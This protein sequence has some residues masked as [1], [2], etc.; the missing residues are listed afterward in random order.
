MN[1]LDEFYS[2]NSN[3]YRMIH[4]FKSVFLVSSSQCNL[5]FQNGFLARSTGNYGNLWLNV[6]FWQN[7]GIRQSTRT[8]G[9]L[10]IC[11]FLIFRLCLKKK[12]QT[13]HFVYHSICQCQFISNVLY[14]RWIR[15]YPK[16]KLII[17]LL[18]SKQ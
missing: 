15:K 7:S 2:Y 12:M 1:A 18:L 6:R 11:I 4:D 13:H 10:C 14:T 8:C 3:T 9:S 16:G 5:F 17:C